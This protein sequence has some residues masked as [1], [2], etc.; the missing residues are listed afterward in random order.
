MHSLLYARA[1]TIGLEF[2]FLKSERTFGTADTEL[3]RRDLKETTD[4]FAEYMRLDDI[5]SSSEVHECMIC[6]CQPVLTLS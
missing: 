2:V 6:Q 5:L 1:T 4:F 3:L